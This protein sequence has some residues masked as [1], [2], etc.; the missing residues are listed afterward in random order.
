PHQ[1]FQ[2]HGWLRQWANHY[3]DHRTRLSI[4]VARQDGRLVMVWPLVAIRALGLTRLC[5]MGEPVSQYG[6]VVVEDGPARFDLLRQSWTLVK[7]LGA[8]VI[9]LRKTR[10]DAVVFPLLQQADAVA[11]DFAAA[12]YL[13]LSDTDDYESYQRRYPGKKRARRRR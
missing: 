4:L 1:L 5:W 13:D 11:V 8:D 7:S 6:D 9:H 2:T 3:L 12:P 10:S